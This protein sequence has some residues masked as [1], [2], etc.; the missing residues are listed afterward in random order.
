MIGSYEGPVAALEVL[1][2]CRRLV[3]DRGLREVGL[4]L[5]ATR[6]EPLADTGML[7]EVVQ[8]SEQLLAELGSAGFVYE[9]TQVYGVLARVL[10]LTGEVVAL[11]D[12]ITALERAL[13]TAVNPV[14]LIQTLAG[15]A[16]GAAAS[17]EGSLAGS[18]IE[19][20]LATVDL[21]DIEGY[22]QRLPA[23]VRGSILIGRLDLA[24]RIVDGFDARTPLAHLSIATTRA[25]TSEASGDFPAA[26][27]AYRAAARRW[28]E[29]DVSPELAMAALGQ[30]RTLV[31]MGDAARAAEPLGLA[32]D[33]ADRCGMVPCA[34]EA[35]ALLG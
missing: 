32:V 27:D 9:A 19:R 30:G 34:G 18:S 21:R 20:L 10:P 3:R 16:I 24:R 6:L 7:L 4:S 1:E 31:A 17:G 22:A 11:P 15:M 12:V 23:L 13:E 35:R 29:L 8:T 14:D 25:A 5:Q 2:E 26:A 33:V 28:E